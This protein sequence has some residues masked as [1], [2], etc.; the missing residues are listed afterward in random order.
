M[1]AAH[2]IVEFLVG[3]G[4]IT[5]P[6]RAEGKLGRQRDAS[7]D[8]HV[9]AERLFVLVS[10]A[11]E[12]PVLPIARWAKHHPW[13]R[14]VFSLCE[15]K[16]GGIEQRALGIVDHY[17]AIAGNQALPYRTL[18]MAAAGAI[19]SAGCALQIFGVGHAG[20]PN[21]RFAFERKADLKIGRGKFSTAA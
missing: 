2:K 16:V 19:Q 6:P 15:L 4:P 20:A 21:H 5:R 9:I 13:P 7:G 17:P 1:E 11:E 3:V 10:V 14:A 8:L 12:I 18:K